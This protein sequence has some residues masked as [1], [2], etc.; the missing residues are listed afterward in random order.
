MGRGGL[1][2]ISAAGLG[3]EVEAQRARRA[4]TTRDVTLRLEKVFTALKATF[5]DERYIL[6][7]SG[8]VLNDSSFVSVT[9]EIVGE[10]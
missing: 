4:V 9:S 3:V 1:D 5:D 7:K 2:N 10:N 6:T 8:E